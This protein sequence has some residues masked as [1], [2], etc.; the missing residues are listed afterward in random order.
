MSRSHEYAL[1]RLGELGARQPKGKVR[2]FRTLHLVSAASACPPA[3]AKKDAPNRLNHPENDLDC[4][5]CQ[6]AGSELRVDADVVQ[7][8]WNTFDR[9]ISRFQVDWPRRPRTR[10]IAEMSAGQLQR[11]E[12]RLLR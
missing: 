3:T 12:T 1:T 5:H 4:C 7:D 6:S 11:T 10:W 8:E 9:S 2:T